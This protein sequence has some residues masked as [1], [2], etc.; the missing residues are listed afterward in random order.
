[1]VAALPLNVGVETVPVGVTVCVWPASAL[2][3]NVGWVKVPAAIVGTPAGHEIVGC[4][5]VPAA[6]V[7]TPAG[8][9]IVPLGVPALT[10][11]LIATAA[12]VV[13]VDVVMPQTPARLVPVPNVVGLMPR[14]F[15]VP[16]ALGS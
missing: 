9:E 8:Q 12:E 10:A 7:G 5:K 1:M 11:W 6:I 3:V 13:E 16:E 4:V 2:P 15:V 14:K